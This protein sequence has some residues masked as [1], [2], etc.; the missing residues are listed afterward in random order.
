MTENIA[1]RR[2]GAFVVTIVGMGVI[3][4]NVALLYLLVRMTTL[5]VGRW[6][7]GRWPLALVSATAGAFGAWIGIPTV[8]AERAGNRRLFASHIP[9]LL[10]TPLVG[11]GSGAVSSLLIQTFRSRETIEAVPD[12]PSVA[13]VSMLFGACTPLILR[14]LTTPIEVVV[15]APKRNKLD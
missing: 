7:D 10:F 3:A 11:A 1:S 5:G 6:L 8:F 9:W 2:Y 4:I 12:A 13:L 15:A 14:A